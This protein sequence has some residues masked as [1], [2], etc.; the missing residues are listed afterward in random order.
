VPFDPQH[1]LASGWLLGCVTLFTLAVG[2]PLTFV[3]LR[4]ASVLGWPAPGRD[5]HLVIYLGRCLGA[6]ALVL[7]YLVGAAAAAP[8]AHRW[9]FDVLLLASLAMTAVHAWGW[10]QR[11]Q[12]MS[13]NLETFFYAAVAVSTWWIARTL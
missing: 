3:P 8:A 2:L 6:V 5:A 10:L 11:S 9:A 13:E 1:P 7:A 12:P 4:W